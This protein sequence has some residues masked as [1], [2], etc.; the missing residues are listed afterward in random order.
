MIMRRSVQ[1][2]N[3]HKHFNRICYETGM[4]FNELA[5]LINYLVYWGHGILINPILHNS[6]FLLTKRGASY[7]LLQK[8]DKKHLEMSKKFDVEYKEYK[9]TFK[10][11]STS[12]ST[13]EKA[14]L[15]F[16]RPA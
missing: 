3:I 9:D 2:V 12:C 13:L 4:D 7:F 11:A 16:S 8:Q 15:M 10:T 5:P 14:L 1:V 6:I